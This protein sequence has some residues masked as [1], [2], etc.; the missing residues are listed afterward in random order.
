MGWV[1]RVKAKTGSAQRSGSLWIDALPRGH[2]GENA[3]L[4]EQ[5][6][7]G[8]ALNHLALVEDE[9]GIH[10]AQG[11]EPVRDAN[12]GAVF[13]EVVDGALHLRLGL[14][15]ERGGGFIK[16]ED[17]R[18]AHERAGNGD[19][20]PL[21]AGEPQAAFAQRRVVA[22]GQRLNEIVRVGLARGAN[23]FLAGRADFAKGNVLR[24]GVVEEQDVLA[25]QREVKAQIGDADRVERDAIYLDQA[26]AGIVET[27][28]QIDERAFARSAF[29]RQAEPLAAL[30]AKADILQNGA[31]AV[32][33]ADVMEFPERA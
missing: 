4:R 11:G 6:I 29:A 9:D 14:R 10:G 5:L 17:G 12:D 32:G 25:D 27:E 30:E 15:V 22:G 3:A 31:A 8:A 26:R 33:E 2:G 13:R 23:N 21:A 19:T 16:H 18:V 24:D 1:Q 28:E 20:L 7:E